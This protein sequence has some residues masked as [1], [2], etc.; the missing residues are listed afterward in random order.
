MAAKGIRY[1]SRATCATGSRTDASLLLRRFG[2]L[3]RGFL[4]VRRLVEAAARA[5]GYIADDG[6]RGLVVDREEAIGAV[7]R[8]LHFRGEPIVVEAPD[9]LV[10]KPGREIVRGAERRGREFLRAMHDPV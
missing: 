8:L 9:H 3:P 1:E 2:R 10:D 7:E 4:F 5:L 6:P